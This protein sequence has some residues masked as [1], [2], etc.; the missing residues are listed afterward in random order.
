MSRQHYPYFLITLVGYR[1]RTTD[2]NAKIDLSSTRLFLHLR[3][4]RQW[5]MLLLKKMRLLTIWIIYELKLSEFTAKKVHFL[6]NQ[7]KKWSKKIGVLKENR[8][9]WIMKISD[10]RN[11]SKIERINNRNLNWTIVVVQ[12]NFCELSFQRI[13]IC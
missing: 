8:Q 5:K 3:V 1:S 2:L 7:C 11:I 12:R 4:I 10:M 9:S 13:V 6:R